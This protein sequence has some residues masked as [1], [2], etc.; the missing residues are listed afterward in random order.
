MIIKAILACKYLVSLY[1]FILDVDIIS[2]RVSWKQDK[3]K[4]NFIYS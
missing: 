1:G 2:S 3:K 4:K